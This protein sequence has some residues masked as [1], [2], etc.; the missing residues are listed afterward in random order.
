MEQIN[1]LSRSCS[2]RARFLCIGAFSTES[3]RLRQTVFRTFSATRSSAVLNGFPVQ[4][5]IRSANSPHEFPKWNLVPSLLGTHLKKK[6]LSFESCGITRALPGRK[7]PN[8]DSRG[9]AK[10]TNLLIYEIVWHNSGI[11]TE[12]AIETGAN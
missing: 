4:E 2:V 11:G 12:C 10:I 1:G 3:A 6:D 9:S 7:F 5:S 8:Q